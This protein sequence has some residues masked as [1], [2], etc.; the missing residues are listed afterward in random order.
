MYET[1]T[2]I[3]SWPPCWEMSLN[4]LSLEAED[5][6]DPAV[7]FFGLQLNGDGS[8][9]DS[10]LWNEEIS[11]AFNICDYCECMEDRW[12]KFSKLPHAEVFS[13]G[14]SQTSESKYNFVYKYSTML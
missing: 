10:I 5:G 13:S 3:S 9:V 4:D 2:Q 6:L 14:F 11:C 8:W 7:V 12:L 1:D